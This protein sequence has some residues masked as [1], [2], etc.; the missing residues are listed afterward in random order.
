MSLAL[1]ASSL[2]L[3]NVAFAQIFE[4]SEVYIQDVEYWAHGGYDSGNGVTFG[5]ETGPNDFSIACGKKA[6]EQLKA[7]VDTSP[8]EL[9]D[10]ASTGR[11]SFYVIISDWTGKSFHKGSTWF[12]SDSIQKYHC[13]TRKSVEGEGLICD[14]P[15][16]DAILALAKTAAPSD[17]S[18][19]S[20]GKREKKGKKAKH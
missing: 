16:K 17:R 20:V 7:I 1:L 2:V 12:Y 3:S 4:K 10:M 19:D 9:T 15:T 11:D 5:V 13:G 6:F 18:P 8:K 14:C